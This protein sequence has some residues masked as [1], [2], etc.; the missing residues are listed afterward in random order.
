MNI[1]SLKPKYLKRYKE[2]IQLLLKYGQ[3]DLVKSGGLDQAFLDDELDAIEI[4]EG[5]PEQLAQDLEALGPTFVKLGQLLSNRPDLLAQPYLDALSRLQD[6]VEPF[7]YEA[8]EELVSTELGMQ[9]SRV[10]LEFNPEPVAAASLGQVHRARL[11]SG[12]AVAVKVQRPDIRQ[13]IRE[14]LEAFYEIANAIDEH[15]DIGRRYAFK[16]MLEE[17]RKALLRELD[18]RQEAQNLEM[19]FTNLRQSPR[20]M[21]PRPFEAYTTSRVL[22][23][24]Y[25]SGTKVTE[26]SPLLRKE[27]D[28]DALANA[29][30]QA[31]LEHILVKG[32]FHADPHPGNILIT[33]DWQLALID[34]G[35]VGYLN[36]DL[37]DNFL[38]LVI[39]ISEG[40][41]S[42]AAEIIIKLGQRLDDADEAHFTRGISDVVARYQNATLEQISMGRIVMELARISA[43]NGIRP[44]LELALVGKVLFHLDEVGRALNPDF[45]PNK[46]IREYTDSIMG[47]HLWETLSPSKIFSSILEL[48]EFIQQ[49]PPRLNTLLDS[50]VTRQFT[51]KVEAFDE[52]LLMR[53]L[54]KIANRITMGLVLAALIVGAALIMSVET[55]FTLFGYPAV[56]IILFFIATGC[57]LALVANIFVQDVWKQQ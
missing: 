15:T 50:L 34:V 25:I 18:Y 29:L 23:M 32:V 5:R 19:L 33:D 35:M 47:Q 38:R 42:K 12:Q 4:D 40:Q 37:K 36:S 45:E 14:D 56:A 44:A 1:S 16:D 43:E 31:Y 27:L 57:G 46:V 26:L 24:E 6:K 55:S 13:I 54:Q 22:T 51:I 7:S 10:F 53:N 48:N 17:F 20:I 30:C 28:G 2:L 41:S 21:A 49:L 39:A 9:L 3:S 8:V 11:M 52:T